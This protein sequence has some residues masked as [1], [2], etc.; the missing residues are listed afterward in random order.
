M[1][2]QL[3]AL[4]KQH[5]GFAI[6]NIVKEVL[7]NIDFDQEGIVKVEK[8]SDGSITQIN[9]DTKILNDIL[10]TALN[11]IDESLLA[12]QDGLADPTTKEVFYDDGVIYEVPLGYL[13]HI[14]FLYNVGP[15]I[16]VRMKMMNDVTG[17][18][19]TKTE[20]YGINNTMVK[21]SLK[22]NVSAE[23]LT[24][25]R[26]TSLLETSEI[27]IVLQIVNGKTPSISPYN[28]TTNP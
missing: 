21:I 20:P 1:E 13:T 3:V 22:V 25:L 6:N 10:Y 9:Y 27:P 24:Y 11:T 26:T 23:V 8:G 19:K 18:I 14:Y 5:T 28:T 16:K 15:K 2:P 12:A 4:A 7:S 17:E